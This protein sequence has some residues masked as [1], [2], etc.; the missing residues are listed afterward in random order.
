M[1]RRYHSLRIYLV[2]LFLVSTLTLSRNIF[3]QE[4]YW[5]KLGGPYDDQI[6]DILTTPN[7][8]I[9]ASIS[10]GGLFLSIDNGYNWSKIYNEIVYSI[11]FFNGKL[12][13]ASNNLLLISTNYGQDWI[14]REH[15]FTFKK[16]A[17]N[18]QGIIFGAK[19]GFNGGL[20]K[21]SDEGNAWEIVFSQNIGSI[22]F[23]QD[24]AIFIITKDDYISSTYYLNFFK[25]TDNGNTWLEVNFPGISIPHYNVAA[26]NHTGILFV[27]I[28]NYHDFSSAVYRSTDSGVTWEACDQKNKT[29]IPNSFYS[30]SNNFMYSG[31]DQGVAKSTDNGKSWDLLNLGSEYININS[32]TINSLGHILACAVHP[33]KIFGLWRSTDE[34][35][36]WHQTGFD[37]IAQVKAVT[38]DEHNNILL[39]TFKNIFKSIA[40]G[41]GW[42]LL[43]YISSYGI[44]SL[45]ID[46]K[47]KIYA[48]GKPVYVSDETG[49]NFVRLFL[50]Y[51]PVANTICFKDTKFF[52]RRCLG[53][54]PR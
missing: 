53:K 3:G 2:L 30:E 40:G 11:C 13:A 10:Y 52:P 18:N 29:F 8:Y 19:L 42:E 21:S 44:N 25:S 39:A 28:K 33:T 15:P 50:P 23:Q 9:F 27:G 22:A 41:T 51:E 48:I 14:I 38:F 45:A 35:L 46:T 54:K 36:T 4:N 7:G 20:L 37:N 24:D 12:F 16:I 26:T 5:E 47:G 49:H 31:V 6:L 34:G 43:L 17:T 1:L 32:I